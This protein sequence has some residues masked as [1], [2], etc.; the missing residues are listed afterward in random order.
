M[1]FAAVGVAGAMLAVS[2]CSIT[3][4]GSAVDTRKKA[5]TIGLV[6]NRSRETHTAEDFA[7][8][9][10]S[11]SGT[12]LEVKALEAKGDKR[13]G[14]AVIVISLTVTRSSGMY[15][16]PETVT[17]CYRYTIRDGMHDHEP[18]RVDC[19]NRDPLALPTP[20]PTPVW[21]L[22]Q[23]A[24]QRLR[25]ALRGMPTRD[26][27]DP[28]GAGRGEA[29]RAGPGCDPRCHRVSGRGGD[30]GVGGPV[31]LRHGEDP[32]REE[33]PGGG[34]APGTRLPSAR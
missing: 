13:K 16:E 3:W 25:T 18:Q 19:P 20:S 1:G 29:R 8:R 17:Q 24:E 26:R 10:V 14:G 6:I 34:V 30:R 27:H 23:G 5:E 11:L 12:G 32:R 31:R 28:G 15:G 9:A 2:A 33:R 4:G 22:P 21:R 7:R